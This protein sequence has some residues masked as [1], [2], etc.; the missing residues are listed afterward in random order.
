MATNYLHD[1]TKI[2]D[3]AI[4]KY[5]GISTA[6]N[7]EDPSKFSQQENYKEKVLGFRKEI[8]TK[9]I[10]KITDIFNLIEEFVDEETLSLYSIEKSFNFVKKY[11][12]SKPIIKSIMNKFDKHIRTSINK[13]ILSPF[14]ITAKVQRKSVW[15]DEYLDKLMVKDKRKTNTPTNRYRLPDDETSKIPAWDIQIKIPLPSINVTNANQDF[16]VDIPMTMLDAAGVVP[17][18]TLNV[19]YQFKPL[20]KFFVE[21][22]NKI[23]DYKK[24]INLFIVDLMKH[25]ERQMSFANNVRK[26]YD[27][28][29]GHP[30][31]SDSG[32]WCPGD[33]ERSLDRAFSAMDIT[34][35]ATIVQKWMSNYV[36][37]Y[38]NPHRDIMSFYEWLPEDL[39][40]N[41]ELL[42]FRQ[43]MGR[44]CWSKHESTDVCKA[45]KCVFINI[46]DTYIANKSNEEVTEATC[47]SARESVDATNNSVI[48]PNLSDAERR[49]NLLVADNMGL[50]ELRQNHSEEIFSIAN[51]PNN[52][53]IINFLYARLDDRE[54]EMILESYMDRIYEYMR[55]SSEEDIIN[56]YEEIPECVL[57]PIINHTPSLFSIG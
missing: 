24:D 20:S 44:S 42:P 46:C 16:N 31:I 4:E 45:R 30:Y 27:S 29:N 32:S 43:S 39:G 21:N 40:T 38:T 34:L 53:N 49:E 26:R 56:L 10:I 1:F 51:K 3:G 47:A 12:N 22:I 57:L 50:S 25:S 14:G 41:P 17:S 2:L 15:G 18:I 48:L 35:L 7:L 11:K 8:R 13:D 37:G 19:S 6:I 36:V 33:Y 23:N 28:T 5:D 54:D 52:T 55:G 9:K